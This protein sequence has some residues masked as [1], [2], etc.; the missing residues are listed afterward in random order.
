[1]MM[2]SFRSSR[3][4]RRAVLVMRADRK[5]W[6]HEGVWC[7]G[8]TVRGCDGSGAKLVRR[9]AGRAPHLNPGTVAPSHPRTYRFVFFGRSCR[10][11]F[12]IRPMQRTMLAVV[13]LAALLTAPLQATDPVAP[14][15]W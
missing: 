7:E 4:R 10:S 3:A 15:V 11:W 8:A 6:G 1:M 12:R 9:F 5:P 14:I 13:T 2:M